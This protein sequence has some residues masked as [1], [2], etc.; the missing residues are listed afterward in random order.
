MSSIILCMSARPQP[1]RISLHK[2]NEAIR[3]AHLICKDYERTNECRVA[4]SYADDLTRAWRIQTRREDEKKEIEWF[5][6][7]ETR[8]YDV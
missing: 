3:H 5:S 6:D 4:W 7:L 1:K 8:E 2:V